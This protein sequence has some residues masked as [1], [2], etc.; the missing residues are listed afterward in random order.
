[1]ALGAWNVSVPQL[2][3]RALANRHMGTSDPNVG[4]SWESLAYAAGQY[5]ISTEGLTN[6]SSYRRWTL[7]DLAVEL[8]QGHPVM[9]LVR[10][11]DLPDNLQSTFAGDHYILALGF[12]ASGNLVYNDSASRDGAYRTITPSQ[13]L[14]AWGEPASG[15]S[16]T[17]MAFYR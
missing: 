2:T 6:G 10:Y 5:G 3:L 13:L 16:F 14:K 11:W 15:L 17:A 4:T 9:L 7:Q 1:M 12:D 8:R